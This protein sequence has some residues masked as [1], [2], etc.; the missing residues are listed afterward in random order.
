[1]ATVP[2]SPRASYPLSGEAGRPGPQRQGEHG[3]VRGSP[4]LAA[5]G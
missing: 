5:L 1:M 4:T 3:G 2:A